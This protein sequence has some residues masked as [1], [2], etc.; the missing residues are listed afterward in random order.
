[1][2]Q[3]ALVKIFMSFLSSKGIEFYRNGQRM[4]LREVREL[5]DEFMDELEEIPAG[6]GK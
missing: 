6:G 3:Q 1:M 4:Q 5:T 2:S